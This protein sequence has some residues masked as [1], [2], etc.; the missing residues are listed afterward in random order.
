MAWQY[1]ITPYNPT[2]SG[3]GINSKYPASRLATRHEPLRQSRTTALSG[4]WTFDL[5]VVPTNRPW[6]SIEN[7]N[8]LSWQEEQADNAGF[9]VNY[10]SALIDV[11]TVVNN[12]EDGQR[13]Y[14]HQLQVPRRYLK[15]HPAVMGERHG[16]LL[17]VGKRGDEW[18]SDIPLAKRHARRKAEH[19]PRGGRDK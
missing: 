5:G 2:V 16:E 10:A 15:N 8:F 3:S 6:V 11:T 7:F 18:D 14:L 19:V 17:N 4:S 12:T 13:M 9:S 1:S